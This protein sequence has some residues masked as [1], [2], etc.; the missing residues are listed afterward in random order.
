MKKNRNTRRSAD[1]VNRSRRDL[2]RNAGLFGAALAGSTATGRTMAA[3]PEPAADDRIAVR[4]ALENLTALEAETLEAVT[5]RI[6]PSD[7]NGPGARE[8]RA[9]HYIDRSLGAH[10]ADSRELYANGLNALEEYARAEYDAAF[11]ELSPGQ[12][13]AVLSQL[14]TGD[15][16]GFLPGSAGFFDTL[17]DHTIEGTFSDPYYGGNRDFI[18]WDLLG[19]PGVRLGTTPEEVA[20]GRA[21]AP[22][23]RSAYDHEDFTKT[24]NGGQ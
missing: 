4:E 11:T 1:P 20:R 3:E 22:S 10:N 15:L 13:D 19:Y 21:L 16:E 6:L 8:A 17:R 14:E 2:L 5:D 23:R 9:V 7:E 12:Q 24:G 18:G